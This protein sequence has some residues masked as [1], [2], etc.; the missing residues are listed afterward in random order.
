MFEFLSKKK[1][2]RRCLKHKNKEEKS[3]YFNVCTK[4]STT[5]A[6]H[7]HSF[8]SFFSFQLLTLHIN[9]LKIKR[10]NLST[11]LI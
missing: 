1:T 4:S 9:T 8:H 7:F 3:Q 11:H 2:K 6:L 10:M 5:K